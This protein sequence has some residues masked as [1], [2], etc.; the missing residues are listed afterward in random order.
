MSTATILSSRVTCIHYESGG[1]NYALCHISS[2]ICDQIQWTKINGNG[3]TY[4][5]GCI[6]EINEISDFV[7]SNKCMV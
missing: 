3:N 5:N 2:A 4:S 1:I 7:M 6:K